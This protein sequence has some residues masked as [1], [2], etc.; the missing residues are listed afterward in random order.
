MNELKENNQ[1]IIFTDWKWMCYNLGI[2]CLPYI[3]TFYLA[4]GAL[5][6]F[7]PIMG[8]AGAGI[9]SEVVIA[10]MVSLLFC[11]LLSFVVIKHFFYYNNKQ[12]I[13]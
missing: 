10:N 5:S 2:L 9:N 6:L 13:V 8:R 1:I 4:I 11:Q 12:F 3:Q 7:I